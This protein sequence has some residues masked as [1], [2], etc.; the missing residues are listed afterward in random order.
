VASNSKQC[1]LCGIEK[2]LGK[3]SGKRITCNQCRALDNKARGE[4]YDGFF[5]ARHA[6]LIQRHKKFEG[7]GTPITI[8]ELKQLYSDQKGICAITKLP[9]H[10]TSKNTDLSASPDRIDTSRGYEKDNVRLVCSRANVMR[11]NLDDH[12]F[13]WWC[14]AVINAY[15]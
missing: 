10:A 7:A 8:E 5:K 1:T 14:R 4:T 9:M 6:K 2:D 11:M 3:F 13:L 15:D 12:D